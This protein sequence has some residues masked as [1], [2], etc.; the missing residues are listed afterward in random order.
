MNK[1]I[2]EMEEE[3]DALKR[4][5][6]ELNSE[7]QTLNIVL[8]GSKSLDIVGVFDRLKESEK[9][10]TTI[11]EKFNLIK[12]DLDL[13]LKNI[14]LK[15]QE[16]LIFKVKLETYIDTLSSKIFW[17]ILFSVLVSGAILVMWSKGGYSFVVKLIK[18]LLN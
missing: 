16:I 7:L 12:Q 11:D 3:I 8:K 18:Q 6:H 2:K 14:D 5:I 9:L 4:N 17:R 15:F 13:K 1:S 10:S